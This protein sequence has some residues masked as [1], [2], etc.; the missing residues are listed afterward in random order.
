MLWQKWAEAE[1]EGAIKDF[2]PP[3]SCNTFVL[4]PRTFLGAGLERKLYWEAARTG[5][6][7][8]DLNE[9]RGGVIILLYRF[10]LYG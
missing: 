2:F 10:L 8:P 1:I 9:E 3:F 6:R 5:L 7:S 4:R